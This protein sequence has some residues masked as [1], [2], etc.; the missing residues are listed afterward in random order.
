MTQQN[1]Q[2]AYSRQNWQT[3]LQDIFG[4]QMQFE[5]QAETI[6]IDR[7]NIKSV[8]R[9]ASVKLADG[10]T[11]A[12][13]D[14][15]TRAGVQIARNRVGLH[16][17]VEKFI[18]HA[19]YHGILA[20]YHNDNSEYRMSFISREPTIDAAGNFTVQGTAPKRYTY[21]LGENEKT[22]TP[23][24][25]LK[26]IAAKNGKATLEDVKNAF[27]VEVL[28]KEFY[29]IVATQ[30]YKLVG[31]TAGK[32]RKATTY[33]RVLQL[34]SIN[35]DDNHT[36]KIYQ[37]FAVR[38]IGRTVFC[39]FL[40]KKKPKVGESLLPEY[41]LSSKA[42]RE[43]SNYYHSILEKLFFQTLNTP[44]DKRIE[45]LPDGCE[46]IP[47][48]N[49]GL[50][51]PQSEDYYLV[52]I[53]TGF[54]NH[55][56]TL[57]IPDD[58]F[59]ELFSNLE[60]FNFTID[61][62]SVADVEVSVDPEILGRIFENLLAEID[63]DSGEMARNATGSFY[64]PREI[65]DYMAVESLTSYIFTQLKIKNEILS[66]EQDDLRM[67]FHFDGTIDENTKIIKYKTD[68]L[69]ALDN[70]K[71]LDP[72]C[73]SGAFPI[74]VLQ[75]IVMALQKLDINAVWWKSKQ[76]EKIDNVVLRN[77]VK[78]KL[79]QSTVEYAR[80]I[81]IIQNSLYG[82]DIQPIAAE[83]SKLRC[84]LTLIVDENIDDTKPNR[85]VEPLPNLEFKFV[86]ANSL[87]QLP[88]E[89]DF[90]GLF[91]SNDNLNDL[92]KIRLEY[93]QSYGEEK[94]ELKERF[95]KLQ[96]NIYKEQ[97]N[98]GGAT[99]LNGR[100]YKISAWN[101]F[102]HDRTDWFDTEWMFGLKDG[103]DIV[104]GNPPYNEIR[105]L[106]KS[107]QIELK[108]SK[109][110]EYAKGGRINLYQF[111]Y[112]LG[113]DIATKSGIITMITQNSILAEDSAFKNR[114]LIFDLCNIDKIDSFPERDNVSKRVF[115]TVKMS[116]A[117][118]FL[119][120]EQNVQNDSQFL[121]K[122]HKDRYLND[123]SRF[124]I[125]KNEIRLI[126]PNN[127][128][129]PLANK[130]TYPILLKINNIKQKC[131]L[132]SS[133][134][135]IDMTKYKPYFKFKG[136]YR[137]ITGAQVQRYFITDC[138][139]QGH[140]MY[141]DKKDIS[142][143][144]QRM[145]EMQT[146]RIAFQRITGVDSRIRIIAS[147]IE[148]NTLCANSTNTIYK[149]DDNLSLIVT[150]GILNCK[151]INFY[152]KQTSTNTNVTTSEINRIPIPIISNEQQKPII[153]LVNQILYLKTKNNFPVSDIVSNE[154]IASYFEKV[155]DACVYELYFEEEIKSAQVDVLEL[156]QKAQDKV[157][158]LPIEQQILHLFEEWNDYKN[159]VRNRII[160]QETR[161]ESVAQI[162]KSTNS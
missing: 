11:L 72:A 9:F 82:V 153:S 50:F 46:Q 123:Y 26:I 84:F 119:R 36:K 126:Y 156:I 47:F 31:A 147:I 75:K 130:E 118:L 122:I 63:P 149:V 3:W 20:F 129:I 57:K 73:G 41:L 58:W 32:G 87:L 80:K 76:I 100:A 35:S 142:L 150:L 90:G 1:L 133:A 39:W 134:G 157:S 158:S 132:R 103:F 51:E 113:I 146:K 143:T 45:N 109:Y 10:K 60:Q 23:A 101:P 125:S 88:Q 16:N 121:L 77:I 15:E 79:E 38:L 155:I 112:P 97:I 135:E 99:N 67:L 65:V 93:L 33:E 21:I 4:S 105:D 108:Q 6:D 136:Q 94:R 124:F 25:R 115:E 78:Q 34:P 55:I 12:V 66:I 42:V 7:E 44:I 2:Q 62:N 49:G 91:N 120:K 116:V 83:I 86:T 140:V 53:I 151:L 64:T 71:I 131:F 8:Q 128:I 48:L 27:S 154:I 22:K 95:L 18:D 162:I 104:I 127:L 19:R 111:F 28:N 144:P 159:E 89:N 14:I 40:K 54:S 137:V 148:E 107:Q 74:G 61:E 13:L 56:N 30:F 117:I 138:P 17:L 24:D 152:F 70:L 5:M 69:N 139:S 92:H 29:N 102:N 68:I 161:S 96:K 43:N 52:N 81:G 145:L 85:G 110:Y 114:E 141:L 37:E 106:S 59:Y 160:L 98:L